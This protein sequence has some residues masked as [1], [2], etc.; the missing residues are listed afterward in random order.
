MSTITL[1][2]ALDTIMQLPLEQQ[3]MLIEIWYKRRIETRR[4]EIAKDAQDT[5]AAFRSGQYKPQP[6]TRIIAELRSSLTETLSG[7]DEE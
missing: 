7:E 3:D 4:Q 1:D 6:V 2:K 5:L